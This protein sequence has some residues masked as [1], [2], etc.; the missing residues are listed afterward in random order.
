MIIFK[1]VYFAY[2]KV[3][4]STLV[5]VSFPATIPL[6]LKAIARMMADMLSMSNVPISSLAL[7]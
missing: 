7:W 2:R 1:V 6:A 5:G 3:L 4:V